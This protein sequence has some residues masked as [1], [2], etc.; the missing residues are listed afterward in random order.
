MPFPC[1]NPVVVLKCFC[2]VNQKLHQFIWRKVLPV[3]L[4]ATPQMMNAQD[5]LPEPAVSRDYLVENWLADEGLPRDTISSIVQDKTG[6][7]WLATPPFGMIRFD[8]LRFA[9]F[10]QEVSTALTQGEVWQALSDR[11]AGLW[12]TSRRTGL[13]RLLNGEVRSYGWD[14]GSEPVALEIPDERGSMSAADNGR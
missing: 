6:Y 8:G 10:G 4:L 2:H 14:S 12:L 5:A 7:L 1:Y 13:L 9:T 11:D 3:L